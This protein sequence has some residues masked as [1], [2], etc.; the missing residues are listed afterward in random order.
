MFDAVY[1]NLIKNL[2][3]EQFSAEQKKQFQQSFIKYN[4]KQDS[5]RRVKKTWRDLC[6]DLAYEIEYEQKK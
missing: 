4:D 1:N 3:E 2:R 6:P 5:F